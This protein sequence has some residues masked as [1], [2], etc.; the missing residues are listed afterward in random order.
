MK[1]LRIIGSSLIISLLL[2][3]VISTTVLAIPT[4]VT[5]LTANPSNTSII[6]SWTIASG[7]TSTVVRYATD[8]FPANAAAGTSAYSGAGS[9]VTVSGLTAGQV[10]YFAA[11]G[12]DGADYSASA[13]ELAMSTLSIALPSGAADT[14]PNTLPE[15]TLP[16]NAKLEPDPSGLNLEPFT[17]MIT[18][19]N[20][21]DGGFGMPEGNAWEFIVILGIV[22]VGGLTYIRMRQFFIAFGVVFILS[23]VG[24]GLELVQGY[25]VVF[26]LIIGLG[27]WA[28]ERY[29]Q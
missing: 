18:W 24:V 12:Y 27:V 28:I 19:F 9:Q 5:N 29:M 6:L 20:E 21:A 16:D 13:C 4:T 2:I 10:Y 25:L 1:K 22:G 8:G 15:L 14:A 23:M 7:S 3:C 17:G 26:E 11:W